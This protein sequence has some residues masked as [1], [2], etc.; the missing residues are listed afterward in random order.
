MS[1]TAGGEDMTVLRGPSSHGKASHP[2][3]ILDDS[4]IKFHDGSQNNYGAPSGGGI[5][6]EI[7][8]DGRAFFSGQVKGRPPRRLTRV[9]QVALLGLL[10]ALIGG[11][12][13]AWGFETHM[14][15]SRNASS[16]AIWYAPNDV[17][18]L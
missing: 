10:G 18:A 4:G 17:P 8:P 5:T 11:L 16:P 9:G 13:V 3:W 1:T 7:A 14:R 2:R 15:D 6:V 12:A